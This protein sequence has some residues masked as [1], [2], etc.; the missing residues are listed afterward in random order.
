MFPYLNSARFAQFGFSTSNPSTHAEAEQ[1]GMILHRISTPEEIIYADGRTVETRKDLILT[2]SLFAAPRTTPS[3]FAN[4]RQDYAYR[5]RVDNTSLKTLVKTYGAA[6]IGYYSNEKSGTNFNAN[7]DA[8]YDASSW[9]ANHEITI[10]GWN[11]NYPKENFLTQPSSNGA[12]LARNNW[13]RF[14]GSNGGYE[15]I[16]YEQLIGEGAVCVVK[17]RP[18]NLSVYEYDSLGWC[19]TYTYRQK[20]IWGANVFQV[21][22]T[23]EKLHS[24]SFYTP[25]ANNQVDIY[26]YDIGTSQVIENPADG[27]LLASKTEVMPYPGYHTV[28]LPATD[29][30]KGHYFSVVIKYT[31][32][33][34]GDDQIA[35]VP[36]EVAIKGYSGNVAVYDHESYISN[37]G[38][39]DDWIDGTALTN[40]FAGGVPY[41]ANVCIK[42]FT[43]APN[44]DY[45][46]E[47]PKSIWDRVPTDVNP[48]HM[49]INDPATT[50]T[51]RVT[52]TLAGAEP[53]TEVYVY[54]SEKTRTYEPVARIAGDMIDTQQAKG[55]A[56]PSEWVLLP[57]SSLLT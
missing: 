4:Q 28:E 33:N 7:T 18:E 2:D 31:N 39:P 46:E 22:T 25:V 44:N 14:D 32:L 37:S 10:I 11:D 26:V 55:L 53:N 9:L 6:M 52:F 23:G 35:G 36:I 3:S 16:S 42:A 40:D 41:H 13:G 21:R 27:T 34:A 54:L 24:V 38:D 56:G 30:V 50:P 15:C 5:N 47:E 8:Y 45:V 19:N 51:S 57:E 48:V 20:S 49:V 43:I 17:K 1:A 29:L 12:W